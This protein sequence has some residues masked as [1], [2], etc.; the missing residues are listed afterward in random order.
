MKKIL[1]FI[2]PII[3]LIGF[4][5]PITQ[6]S[7]KSL[8]HLLEDSSYPTEDIIL[9]DYTKDGAYIYND[10]SEDNN[11]CFY[12]RKSYL[13]WKYDY[14][15]HSNVSTLKNQSG[16]SLSALPK[17]KHV[18]K[19]VYFGKVIDEEI[20][21]ITFKNMKTQKTENATIREIENIK[22]WTKYVDNLRK[23]GYIVSSYDKNGEL[24]SQLEVDSEK[25]K[26]KFYKNIDK[27]VNLKTLYQ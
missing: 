8:R 10:F 5:F 9:I 12:M 22:I 15:V 11:I 6:N 19:P 24:I 2:I 7:E 16:F 20:N 18:K 4:V 21:K 1:K 14:D 26:Y 17:K 27:E 23:D 25:T 3:L 13:G